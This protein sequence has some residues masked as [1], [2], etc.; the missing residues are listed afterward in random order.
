[1]TAPLD[2]SWKAHYMPEDVA[3]IEELEKHEILSLRE[4]A[5]ELKL[6]QPRLPLTHHLQ[7]TPLFEL[8]SISL[9]TNTI[10]E[11]EDDNPVLAVYGNV[12]LIDYDTKNVFTLFH[13][14]SS[15]P[16]Y[17]PLLDNDDISVIIEKSELGCPHLLP[18]SFVLEISLRDF[19]RGICLINAKREIMFKSNVPY[20]KDVD[21]ELSDT[22]GMGGDFRVCCTVF[23]CAVVAN[24]EFV[25]HRIEGGSDEIEPYAYVSGTIF[26]TYRDRGRNDSH[27]RVLFDKVIEPKFEDP[28]KLAPLAVPAYSFLT[29]YADLTVN[30][31]KIVCNDDPWECKAKD[32]SCSAHEKEILGH[33]YRVVLRGRWEH[34][35]DNG[36]PEW[37][38]TQGVSSEEDEN[39]FSEWRDI[40][41]KGRSTLMN[42][43]QMTLPR[44][45]K[46]RVGAFV[47]RCCQLFVLYFNFHYIK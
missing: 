32:N 37:N 17:V 47:F 4:L 10:P 22:S 36:F 31:E 28:V 12:Q 19:T 5:K 35:L 7:A 9:R 15:A 39:S 16:R 46:P 25:V 3:H 21:I 30:G 34:L 11:L 18:K 23:Q 43:H 33:K 6:L 24:V 45:K 41:H 20:D 27:K 42:P 1:M 14:E 38:D 13:R 29:I 40:P 8:S 26:A 44:H 2:D